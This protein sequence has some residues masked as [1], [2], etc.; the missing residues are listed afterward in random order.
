MCNRSEAGPSPAVDEGRVSVTVLAP[1]YNEEAVL[2]QFCAAVIGQLGPDW[3][4]LLV[5]DGSTDRTREIAEHFARADARVRL[6]AYD[7]NRG[8]GAALSTGIAHARGDL[9]ITMDADLSHPL[10]LLPAMIAKC[11]D[12]D[13]VFASRFIPGGG[14]VDIPW[15]RIVSSQ[16]A[17][18]MLRVVFAT[19]TH[20][21]TTGFRVYRRTALC[22]VRVQAHGFAAQLELTVRLQAAGYRAAEVPFVLGSRAAGSSKMRYFALIPRYAATTVRLLGVRWRCRKA[23]RAAPISLASCNSAVSDMK[24][25]QHPERP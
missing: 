5:D 23:R 10:E 24:T 16:I 12:A 9:V 15:W 1:A 25:A 3:E 14:M 21:L 17:N 4:L 22:D 8:I 6:V 2:E 13:V 18:R 19:R 20:D 11:A 7:A